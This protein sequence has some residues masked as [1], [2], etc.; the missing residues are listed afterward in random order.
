[1]YEC[2]QDKEAAVSSSPTHVKHPPPAQR[3]CVT[4]SC[5]IHCMLF[6]RFNTYYC[7]NLC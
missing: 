2:V 3:R 6:M 1:M 7:S 5:R 4:L